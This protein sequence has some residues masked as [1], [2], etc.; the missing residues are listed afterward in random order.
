[1]TLRDLA[2][3]VNPVR[4]G[5]RLFKRGQ[6]TQSISRQ[7]SRYSCCI[8]GRLEFFDK[9]YFMDGS[10]ME[11]SLGGALFRSASTFMLDRRGEMI[12]IHFDK[13]TR[14]GQIMNLR[15]EGYGLRF[16]EPLTEA[17]LL[18]IAKAFGLKEIDYFH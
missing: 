13:Y 4:I 9:G 14:R 12:R 7:H 5:R 17:E 18:P 3:T 6:S 8:V 16:I 15:P 11:I 1:M 10:V 2:S